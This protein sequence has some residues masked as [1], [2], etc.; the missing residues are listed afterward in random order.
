MA[1]KG[2]QIQT[3]PDE[4]TVSDGTWLNLGQ[5]RE[6]VKMADEHGWRDECLVSHGLSHGHPSL[7]DWQ[8]TTHL[9]VQG[10]R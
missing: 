2:P 5:L 4:L 8:I 10:P 6:L 1:R 9:L 3:T 7:R